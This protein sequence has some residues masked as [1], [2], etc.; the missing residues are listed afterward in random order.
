MHCG[1]RYLRC[2]FAS[3]PITSSY[4]GKYADNSL[5]NLVHSCE[6]S[7]RPVELVAELSAVLGCSLS[8]SCLMPFTTF[9]WCTVASGCT[10][11][12]VV[13]VL[14]VV[15]PVRLE[16]VAAAGSRYW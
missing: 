6:R 11:E 5:L 3:L 12:A 13:E 16:E 8:S 10:S 9:F 14:I 1:V 4:S 15:T 7:L 2:S